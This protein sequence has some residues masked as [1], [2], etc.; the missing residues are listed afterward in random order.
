MKPAAKKAIQIASMCSLS[1]L[2]VYIAKNILGAVS[3]QMIAEGGFATEAIGSMSSV[4]FVTYAIGQ[5]INGKLGDK[6]KAKYMISCGLVLAG[7][8]YLLISA[9]G[10]ASL[11]I[12]AIYGI[13]GLFLSMI[14]GPMTKVVAENTDPE[15]TPRCSLGYT[16]ASFLGSPLA[17]LLGATLAWRSAFAT[18][19][20][21]LLI[22]GLVCF[23]VFS[24]F[25]KKGIVQ[26]GRYKKPKEQ[27]GIGILLKHK[28]IKFTFIAIITGVVRTTVV[29]WL[30]TYLAQYLGFS[31]EKAALA[32][33]AATFVIS[34]TAF[35]AVFLYERLGRNM[36]LTILVAFCS[37]VVCFT[38]VF[39]LKQPVL[40][41]IFLILG[42]MS[43]NCAAS[44]VWSR[45][46]PGLRDTG[47]VSSATGYLDATSYLAAAVSSTVFANAVSVIGWNGLVLV[48]LGLMILGVVIVLPYGKIFKN[49]VN[50]G[51]AL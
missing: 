7:L 24:L 47:M 42:I 23:L 21:A 1:Y 3:P 48:W 39:L 51:S 16:F 26:Y 10:N 36:D 15:Y 9:L 25:E 33:T 2:A 30:P 27:G 41:I 34:T 44:M 13:T 37:A 45:Y 20:S 5:L 8:C 46:C 29:F 11:V 40:N 12:Y 22:M 4:Y 19:S 35:V 17:G 43:S 18:T 14:Y 31:A 6:I 50:T 49:H 38:L 28:I 32:F